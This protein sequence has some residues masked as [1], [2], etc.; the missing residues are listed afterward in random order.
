MS[1][2][3]LRGGDVGAEIL[4]TTILIKQAVSISILACAIW[5]SYV[6]VNSFLLGFAPGIISAIGFGLVSPH[7]AARPFSAGR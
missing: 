1:H 2:I 7:V 5:V 4:K 3:I 6:V